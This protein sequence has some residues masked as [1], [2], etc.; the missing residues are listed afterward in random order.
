MREVERRRSKTGGRESKKVEKFYFSE[1]QWREIESSGG[2]RMV[3]RRSRA[4][5]RVTHREKLRD[6]IKLCHWVPKGS[7]FLKLDQNQWF[8]NSRFHFYLVFI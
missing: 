8:Q 7:I 6:D 1:D 4:I 2:I 3:G 5:G